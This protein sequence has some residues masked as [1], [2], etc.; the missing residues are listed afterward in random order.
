MRHNI[1]LDVEIEDGMLAS[2]KVYDNE[3]L[4]HLSRYD[5]DIILE[6]AIEEEKERW[7]ESL[8]SNYEP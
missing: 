3:I 4:E 7:V 2:V 5:K 8:R 6:K 1:W